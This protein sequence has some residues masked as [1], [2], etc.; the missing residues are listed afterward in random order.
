MMHT[1]SKEANKPVSGLR[2]GL[3]LAGGTGSRLFPTTLATSKQL[4]PIYDKPM[5][6]YPLSVLM[7][8]GIRDVLIITTPEDQ[9][10][11]RKLLGTG[12]NLGIH[13]QY[14]VQPNP[15]GL[16]EAFS[17]GAD[18]VGAAPVCLIL[19]DNFFYGQGFTP[20]LQHASSRSGATLFSYPVKDP[21]RFG[22]VTFDDYGKVLSLVEKP[23]NPASNHAVTGLYFFDNDVIRIADNVQPSARGEKEILD[24]LDAYRQRDCLNVEPLGRGFTWLDAGTP[25]SLLEAGMFVQT[26][27]RRQGLK[28][29]CLEEIAWRSGWIS[30]QQLLARS[31]FLGSTDYGV[32]LRRLLDGPGRSSLLT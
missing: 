5:V 7:L 27:E 25:E 1:T 12:D 8:A 14:A 16:P 22:V 28:I 32:Y 26:I 6:Y 19:G 3:L 23:A 11:Y 13:V 30:D 2:K 17:I 20:L 29:A 18:F 9:T 21:H 4:L 24:V 10:A 15:G 31:S